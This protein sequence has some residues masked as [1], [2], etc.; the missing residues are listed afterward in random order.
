MR[1]SAA[2]ILEIILRWRSRAQLDRPVGFRGGAVGEVGMVLVL[3]LQVLQ[4]I[5]RLL[6]DFLPPS[7]Q[8]L[9]EVVPLALVHE[10]LFVGRPV[11]IPFSP[12]HAPRLH[13]T[14]GPIVG[15]TARPNLPL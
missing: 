6:E 7:E 3:V 4:G 11:V 1:L 8:A 2:S 12:G 15:P 10:W 14:L 13:C 9:A 5:A